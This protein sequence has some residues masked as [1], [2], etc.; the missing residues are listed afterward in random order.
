MKNEE[1]RGF[2]LAFGR[3]ELFSSFQVVYVPSCKTSS[4]TL[5][6]PGCITVDSKS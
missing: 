1:E 3:G 2:I 5:A 4:S 6:G